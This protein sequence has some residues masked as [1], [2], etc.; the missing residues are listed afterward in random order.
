MPYF[1]IKGQDVSES[2][3]DEGMPPG[4]YVT[5]VIADSPGYLAGCLPGDIITVFGE[6]PIISIRDF[7]SRL[8]MLQSGSQVPVEVQRRGIDEYKAIKYNV[9]IGAR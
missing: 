5:E 6:E 1:G 8:E 9:M 7:R 2:M 3:Q 4:I